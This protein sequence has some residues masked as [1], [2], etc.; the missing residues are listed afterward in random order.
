MVRILLAADGSEPCARAVAFVIRHHAIFGETEIHLVNVQPPLPGTAGGHLSREQRRQFHD[1]EGQK[2]L[3]PARKA[4]DDA[5]IKY[6][7]QVAVG[8]PGPAIG[9]YC[10]EHQIDQVVMGTRG[11]SSLQGAILGSVSHD[12]IEACTVPV[13]LVK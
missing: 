12:V 1:E 9:N 13:L 7:A 5:G 4:L 10:R 3:A 11:R 2:A 8:E 6:I